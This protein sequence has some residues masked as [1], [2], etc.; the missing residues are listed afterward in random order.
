MRILTSSVLAILLLVSYAQAAERVLQPATDAPFLS[1][2]V[3][4]GA[5][6][7]GSQKYVA[8]SATSTA[9]R[10]TLKWYERKLEI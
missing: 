1:G 6:I 5:D 3:L 4:L 10:N 7:T 9:Q 2:Y 8:L